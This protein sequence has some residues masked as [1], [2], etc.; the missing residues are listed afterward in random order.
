ML[1]VPVTTRLLAPEEYGKS[2]LF[3]LVQS[4]FI[5]VGLL[6]IDQGYV[7][8]YN[9]KELDKNKLLQ[10]ALFVP[11]CFTIMLSLVCLIFYKKLSLFLFGSIEPV[12]MIA[13]SFFLPVLLLNRFFLLQIRMEL[14][15][16]TYSFLNIFSQIIN[17]SVL[18]IF[19]LYYQKTFRSL[20]YA[21]IIGTSITTILCFLFCDKSFLIKRFSYSK[22]IQKKLISFGLPLVPTTILSWIMNSFDKVALRKWSSFEELGLYAAAFK[23]VAL[24]NVF[25][26]IF[27]TAW[28]PV[29]Y[30]WNEEQVDKRKFE[31]VST[32]S[33][34]VM[35]ILFSLVVVFR[36]WIL[37]FL[38]SQYKNTEEIF[39]FLLF[40][41][42]LYTVSETACL[43]INFSKKTIFNLYV[44]IICTLLNFGG[45]LLLVPKFGALGAAIST[46]FCYIIFFWLRTL[47]SN[48]LWFKFKLLKYFIDIILL[49]S[50]SINMLFWKKKIFE[51]MLLLIVLIFNGVLLLK[52]LFERKYNNAVEK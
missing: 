13:F 29:A 11:L 52:I 47:F 16:K 23:I 31:K 42:V 34:S 19:L 36:K 50:F 26:N 7:R 1:T 38:G 25:Q 4:I 12:L 32:I 22:E 35:T 2:S 39:I 45:N 5:I 44:A 18:V 51:I 8:Y 33:L 30:K 17:F 27:S 15:G 10:N 9:D 49:I 24:L 21:A 28:V 37:F 46:S 14:K 3:S 20:V 48:I 43:G 41:P 40:V 6:G